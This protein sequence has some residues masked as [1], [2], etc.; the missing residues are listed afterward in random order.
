MLFYIYQLTMNI[1][2]NAIKDEIKQ[3]SHCSNLES[4]NILHNKK[5]L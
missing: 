3:F 5:T 1:N 4:T 2:I